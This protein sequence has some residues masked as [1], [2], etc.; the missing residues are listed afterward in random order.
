MA[1]LSVA[2][3]SNVMLCSKSDVAS[4]SS[5]LERPFKLLVKGRTFVLDPQNLSKLSP[6][7]AIVLF[8][9]DYDKDR[10]VIREIV[11][12]KTK[13]FPTILRLANKYQ[14]DSLTDA[15]GQFITDRCDLNR[16]KPDQ[17]LTLLIAAHEFHL[18]REVMV[19]LILRLASEE[20]TTFNRLKLSRLL[21]SQMYGAV[22]GT[23][24]NLTQLKEIE[25]MNNHLFKMERNKTQYRR[26][27]CDLCK[28]ITDAAY[29]EG[30]RQYLCQTHWK[31]IKCPSDYGNRLLEELRSNVV[32]LEWD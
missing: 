31:L 16:L 12:E 23:N 21:P 29:C 19:K 4:M 32:E 11:D 6:I 18:K 25:T 14:V 26:S 22:I 8:G 27:T 17:V 10:E 24:I 13:N 2:I 1:T 20:K 3:N 28:K 7:F 5:S 9:K 15:C 30:C